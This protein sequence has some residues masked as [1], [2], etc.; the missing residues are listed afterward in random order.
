MQCRCKDQR[1]TVNKIDDGLQICLEDVCW[2][3]NLP[4]EELQ[5]ESIVMKC[6]NNRALEVEIP[7]VKANVDYRN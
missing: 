4:V 7:K 2:K 5:V 6:N 1:I 3:L